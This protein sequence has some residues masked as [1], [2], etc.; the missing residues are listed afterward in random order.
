[1]TSYGPLASSYDG[2]THDVDYS[3]WS[4]YLH[5]YLQDNNQKNNISGKIILDLACGTGSL[6][7]ELAK[8]GY[9]MI[10]VDLSPEM[11]C[12]AS[13][14]NCDLPEPAPIFLCQS[15]D[16]L[17]LYG[18]IDGCICCLDSLN[19]LTNLAKFQRTLERVSLFLVSGAMFVFDIKTP[20]LFSKQHGQVTVDETED[21]YCVWRSEF[22]EESQ[23]CRHY[24]DLFQKIGSQWSRFEEEHTQRA[25]SEDCVRS[26]LTQAGF[27]DIR[28]R[29]EFTGAH[30]KNSRILFTAVK[31]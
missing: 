23:L 10:G 6:T 2:L 30:W 21:S 27:Y 8:L 24:V 18:T 15:M 3:Q 5:Q 1:M 25:Y 7:Y 26:A 12:E 14:K 31:K 22:E 20:E 9:E 16:K 13:D 17:D 4:S 11:L 19:Y 29:E 28:V